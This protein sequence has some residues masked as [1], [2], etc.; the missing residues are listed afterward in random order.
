MRIYVVLLL[1]LA[2]LTSVILAVALPKT[3]TVPGVPRSSTYSA[4]E[5][6]AV[7]RH[8]PATVFKITQKYQPGHAK[9]TSDPAETASDTAETSSSD[10]AETSSG[11]KHP[12]HPTA[13]GHRHVPTTTATTPRV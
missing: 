12:H 5:T 11:P 8:H 9:T 1:T 6:S 4:P 3:R 7:P 10:T 13:S 2:V